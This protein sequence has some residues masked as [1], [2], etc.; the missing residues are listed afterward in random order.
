MRLQYQRISSVIKIIAYRMLRARLVRARARARLRRENWCLFAIL[1]AIPF[2]FR[3]RKDDSCRRWTTTNISP[4]FNS[5]Q[6]RRTRCFWQKL[7]KATPTESPPS[8]IGKTD[9]SRDADPGRQ[10]GAFL[11]ADSWNR[12]RLPGQVR[13]FCLTAKEDCECW[14]RISWII[15]FLEFQNSVVA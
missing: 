4:E 13:G 8:Y 11:T 7:I 10:V 9:N 3:I 12:L 2:N 15:A 5:T 1:T 14:E 6:T